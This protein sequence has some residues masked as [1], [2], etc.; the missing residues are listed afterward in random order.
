MTAKPTT[1]EGFGIIDAYTKVETDGKIAEATAALADSAPELLNT[2]AEFAAALGNDPNFATTITT[3]LSLKLNASAYTAADVL[4]KLRTVD[5]SD[6]GLDADTVRGFSTSADMAA[7]TVAL[8]N[9]SGDLVA[10][11]F[12]SEY[13]TTT[14]TAA[15]FMGQH[16]VG[17]DAADNYIRPMTIAQAAALLDDHLLSRQG[18]TV[19]GQV[20]VTGDPGQ[21]YGIVGKPSDAGHGGVLGYTQN[22]AKYGILG[23]ANAYALYG[24]GQ[25]YASERIA[26][27][28]RP[29]VWHQRLC[30][31]RRCFFAD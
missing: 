23:H 8:R 11:L 10:R 26:K 2:L 29:L 25:I 16:A 21:G 1:I 24:V 4:A 6:S 28:R 5:G 12:R 27:C 30:R 19:S 15:Y 14:A 22:Q 9:S 17:A 7:N 31:Q 13:A 20:Y 18:G 3:A